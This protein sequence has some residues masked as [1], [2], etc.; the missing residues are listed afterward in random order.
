M[1]GEEWDSKILF[2][3]QI[4]P[5]KYQFNEVDKSKALPSM[6]TLYKTRIGLL[7]YF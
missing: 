3:L 5:L 2:F 1:M 6:S 7:S 4:G